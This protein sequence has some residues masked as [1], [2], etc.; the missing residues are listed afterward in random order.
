MRHIAR[1]HIAKPVLAAALALGA[2]AWA[3]SPTAAQA[4]SHAPIGV[5][6]GANAINSEAIELNN[7]GYG[8]ARLG[9]YAP[10][11][12]AYNE[13]LRLAPTWA[14]AYANRAM[15]YRQIGETE[16]AL[17][18]VKQSIELDGGMVTRWQQWM[19]RLGFYAGAVDGVHGPIT[20]AAI[21]R[22]AGIPANP[23]SA[24]AAA[25]TPVTQ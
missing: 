17:A 22:W 21:E 25:E 14:S 15:A 5:V 10:A 9:Y 13:A 11:I 4:Q 6:S 19:Q 8:Y 12:E 20:A 18:D 16:K 23:A 3:L 24:P 1:P 2:V 7:R